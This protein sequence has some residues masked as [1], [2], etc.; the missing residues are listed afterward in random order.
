MCSQESVE[1][2]L[3]RDASENQQSKRKKIESVIHVTTLSKK[4]SAWIK[5]HYKI[6]YILKVVNGRNRRW[7]GLKTRSKD[8]KW[9]EEVAQY[10][11]T[12]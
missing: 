2:Q 5:E 12:V 4:N 3:S 10:V 8:N 7:L 9:K 6:R 1:C 11:T